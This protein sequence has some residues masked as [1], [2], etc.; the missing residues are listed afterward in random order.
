MVLVGRVASLAALA[1][2]IS[3]LPAQL[4]VERVTPKAEQI[5]ASPLQPIQWE[6]S[7]PVSESSLG[8][9]TVKVWGRWGGAVPGAIS[10]RDGGYTVRFSPLEPFAPG[11]MVTASLAPPAHGTLRR[12]AGADGDRQHPH[13]RRRTDPQLRRLHRRH[14]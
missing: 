8:R 11:E 9:A 12:A 6:L 1:T 3:A 7:E 10:L 2:V 14:R 13:A 4:A 5:R